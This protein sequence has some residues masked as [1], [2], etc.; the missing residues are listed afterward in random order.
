MPSV[1]VVGLWSLR[2]LR[3]LPTSSDFSLHASWAMWS[4]SESHPIHAQAN[5]TSCKASE[6]LVKG[7]DTAGSKIVYSPKLN[8]NVA[9]IGDVNSPAIH[10][11]PKISNCPMMSHWLRGDS[12]Q[13]E[14]K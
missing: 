5:N 9:K 11:G 1:E 8:L 14:I 13:D 6:A 7:H 3:D 10:G 2:T 4:G 12:G